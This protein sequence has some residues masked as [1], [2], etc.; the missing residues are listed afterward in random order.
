[1]GAYATHFRNARVFRPQPTIKFLCN[2]ALFQRQHSSAGYRKAQSVTW[3]PSAK[4]DCWVLPC[5]TSTGPMS[6]AGDHRRL[7]ARNR[8]PHPYSPTREAG[9]GIHRQRAAVYHC[10]CSTDRT[11]GKP[12]GTRHLVPLQGRKGRLL[13]G[14]QV[15]DCGYKMGLNGVDNSTSHLV[16]RSAGTRENLL[17]RFGDVSPEGVYSSPSTTLPPIFSPCWAPWWAAGLRTRAGLSAAKTG[18]PLP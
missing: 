1:M 5:E 15:E 13:P 14:I 8:V 6:R 18:P 12:R 3:R 11:R 2:S 17:N 16:R 10:V 7:S 9:K 4:G